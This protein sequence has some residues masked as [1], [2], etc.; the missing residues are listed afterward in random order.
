MKLQPTGTIW[1]DG[2]FVPW[3]QAQVH[4]LTP[5]LHYGWGVYEGIRAYPTAEGPAVFRLREH[6][7]RLHDSA[8][9]Y[10]M[11]PGFTVDQLTEAALELLRRVG[12]DSAYLRPIVYLG[13]GTMGVAPQ[14]D[15][16]RVAIAA[17][18]WGS[19][20]GEKAE[21]EG[22]RLTVSSW[23][24]N[25]IHSVPPLAKAT[26][27]Y[28]NS[29][30][31][32][33]AAIRAGYDDALLLTPTGHVAEASAANVFAVRDSV[34]VTPP[35]SDNILP[36]ITRQSLITLARDFGLTVEERSLT[37]GELYVADEAFLTGTA[38]EVVPVASVDDR[39]MGA[40]GCGPVTKQLR[41]A[42]TDVVHGRNPTYRHWLEYA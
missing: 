25:G 35:V 32:K 30:L 31:A 18:P 42:F 2:E 13:Y 36:G 22:C 10:L 28:V 38:T 14:L 7:E 40:G 8:R 39:P 33:V 15:S 11:D 4:V 9:V 29:A 16:A 12:L 6:L 1:M 27:A 19:Y 20:L 26:G 21:Q 17:W 34:L 23:Q 3:D 41:E 24:R 37:R 5:S